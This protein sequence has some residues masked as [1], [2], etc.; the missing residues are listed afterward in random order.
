MKEK[1]KD[2]FTEEYALWITQ[3]GIDSNN[4]LAYSGIAFWVF[5]AFCML[6]GRRLKMYKK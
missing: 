6:T 4:F 3:F 1:I 5:W 2:Y